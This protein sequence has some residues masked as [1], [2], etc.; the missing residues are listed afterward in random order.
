[1]N[2]GVFDPFNIADKYVQFQITKFVVNQ[3]QENCIIGIY[4]LHVRNICS[5]WSVQTIYAIIILIWWSIV[6]KKAV[7][8]PCQ[9][10]S[11]ILR[12][13]TFVTILA[14]FHLE[15]ITNLQN[16]YTILMLNFFFIPLNYV[17]KRHVL[18]V[19]NSENVVIIS[20][21][22]YFVLLFRSQCRPKID[23]Q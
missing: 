10:I 3:V 11:R 6:Y 7:G 17:V 15:N 4:N 23:V 14:H 9:K 1:M 12:C 16:I 5:V 8:N 21:L 2:L 19:R 18:Y 22:K 13:F 20:F